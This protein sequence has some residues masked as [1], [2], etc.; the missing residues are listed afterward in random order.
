MTKIFDWSLDRNAACSHTHTYT[1]TRQHTYIYIT[2]LISHSGC[3]CGLSV[4]RGFESGDL[5]PLQRLVFM[6]QFRPFAPTTNT[7]TN[8]EET[9]QNGTNHS[10]SWTME[11]WQQGCPFSDKIKEPR[12][13]DK[14]QME[15]GL[16]LCGYCRK[17]TLESREVQ[18]KLPMSGAALVLDVVVMVD[19]HHFPLAGFRWCRGQAHSGHATRS[20]Q[21][22]Q[23]ILDQPTT[24][25]ET[26][27]KYRD[28]AE[29]R[30]KKGSPSNLRIGSFTL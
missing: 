26:Q 11:K 29:S 6:L 25:P 1:H 22:E 4:L 24:Q 21:L 17:R 18:A 23:R 15:K 5:F 13:R 12:G 2:S 20:E 3:I 30:G 19:E 7:Q 10:W 27:W 28:E 8:K 14:V 16:Y 9:P